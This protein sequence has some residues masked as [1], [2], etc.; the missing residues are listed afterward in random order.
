M[1]G[2]EAVPPADTPAYTPN[3]SRTTNNSFRTVGNIDP[4]QRWLSLGNRRRTASSPQATTDP[5]AVDLLT[6]RAGQNI[7][8]L[9]PSE[10]RFLAEQWAEIIQREE[11]EYLFANIRESEDLHE[12]VNSVHSE[13]NQRAPSTADIV[14]V[15][16]MALARDMKTLQKLGAKVVVCEEAAEVSEAYIFSALIRGVQHIIQIGDH[17]HHD[18]DDNDNGDEDDQQLRPQINNYT[19]SLENPRGLLYQLDRSQFE[20]LAVG[21]LGLSAIHVAQLNLQRRMRPEISSLIR[22][23]MYRGLHDHSSVTTLPDTCWRARQCL[24]A[25]P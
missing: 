4:L 5:P 2:Y 22:C 18:D 17:Q 1:G 8:S 7:D 9:L 16:T 21:E 20:R 15:T 10:R 13:V 6:A 25:Q 23:T 19:L 14:G 12:R 11:T 24:L 3:W